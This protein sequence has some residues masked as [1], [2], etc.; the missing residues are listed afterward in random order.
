M[1][2]RGDV[3]QVQYGGNGR[4][5]FIVLSETAFN[6]RS[7]TII[8]VIAE[9]GAENI[10]MPLAV[11]LSAQDEGQAIFARPS[12]I[13]TVAQSKCDMK[14]VAHIPKGELDMIVQALNELVKG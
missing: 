6:Q 8:G 2:R 4:I 11:P 9:R 13:H 5:P 3:V 14:P 1:L 7:G 10:G 12:Q